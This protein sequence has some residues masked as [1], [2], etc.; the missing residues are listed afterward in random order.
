MA[1]DLSVVALLSAWR[2]GDEN[3]RDQIITLVLPD[4]RQIAAARL[5]VEANSSL[6]TGD[7]VNDTVLRFLQF[8]HVSIADRAHFIALISRIMRNILTDHARA[9]LTNKRQHQKVELHTQI[10]G[11]QRFDLESLNIALVRLGAID[12]ALMELVEMRYFGGMSIE[13]VALATGQSPA[14][15]KRRWR[16]AR[17][18]LV[19][20]LANQVD[21]GRD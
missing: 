7:L 18:W 5:R 3:A 4:L 20:A 17:A 9:K 1:K 6:S 13:D 12:P 16:V 14:S 21:R 10:N 19:D 11:E 2:A 8:Q 15:V